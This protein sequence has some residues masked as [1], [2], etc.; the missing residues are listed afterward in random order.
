MPLSHLGYTML[1]GPAV[2]KG[3]IRVRHGEENIKVISK[4]LQLEWTFAFK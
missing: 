1:T 3:R 2:S 4:A